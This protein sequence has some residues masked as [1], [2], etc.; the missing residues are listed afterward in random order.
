MSIGD[1]LAMAEEAGLDLVKIAPKANPPV[2]KI[3]DYGKFRYEQ[4]RREKE[5]KKKQKIDTNDLNTKAANARKFL[6]KGI[7]VKVTVRFRGREMAHTQNGR[8]ILDKFAET[9]SDI[10]QVEKEPKM[11]GRN[12]SMVLVEKR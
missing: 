5:A 11:E 6:S 1:A 3:V 7:R 9:L 8:V 10:S 4:T 12:M 2:C